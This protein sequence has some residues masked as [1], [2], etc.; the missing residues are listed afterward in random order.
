MAPLHEEVVM[1]NLKPIGR[2]Q[3]RWW[4]LTLLPGGRWVLDKA[5]SWSAARDLAMGHEKG[6]NPS[7]VTF[8]VDEDQAKRLAVRE[9]YQWSSLKD[10]TTEGE[11]EVVGPTIRRVP[12]GQAGVPGVR[13]VVEAPVIKSRR[14][15]EV[16]AGRGRVI[17]LYGKPGRTRCGESVTHRSVYLV[18]PTLTSTMR[19]CDECELDR[20]LAEQRKQ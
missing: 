19:P 3:G 17:H 20:L 12:A 10:V 15:L 5:P 6:G 2:R 8:A 16:E 13:G 1:H 18:W 14:E 4:V 7:V 9:V 11:L